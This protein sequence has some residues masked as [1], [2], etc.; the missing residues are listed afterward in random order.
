MLGLQRLLGARPGDVADDD[1]TAISC[2]II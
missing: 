1:I 2:R